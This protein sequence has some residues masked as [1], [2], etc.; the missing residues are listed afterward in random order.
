MEMDYTPEEIAAMHDRNEN[1][2]GKRANIGKIK[3]YYSLK[4]DL[5]KFAEH[6]DVRA[7][8]GFDPN[9]REKH[10]IL[11]MDLSPAAM[12]TKEETA[13]LAAILSKSDGAVISAQD[14]HARIA[15]DVKNIWEE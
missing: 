10:A 4:N 15:L 13:E 3:L 5:I 14:D 2:V 6:E 12:F 11:W 9:V 1:F 7:V 8:D